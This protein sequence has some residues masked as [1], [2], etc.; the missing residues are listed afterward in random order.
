[1][2]AWLALAAGLVGLVPA[3]AVAQD[4]EAHQH[5]PAA[6]T[7]AGAEPFAHG[8]HLADGSPPTRTAPALAG[9]AAA[10]TPGAATCEHC[11]PPACAMVAHCGGPGAALLAKPAT[12]G[13]R[14]A[15]TRRP[16]AASPQPRSHTVQPPT[17]PPHA[18]P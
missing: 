5:A 10:V 17:P 15:D 3:P 11:P 6:G 18:L 14:A 8:D 12:P 4:C 9:D 16:A 1:M 13:D 7:T 2:G